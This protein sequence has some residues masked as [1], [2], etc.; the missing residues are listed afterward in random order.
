M[1]KKTKKTK[2]PKIGDTV[3]I[4]NKYNMGSISKEKVGFI[5]VESFVLDGFQSYDIDEA[6]QFYDDYGNTWFTNLAKAKK[7]A[8]NEARKYFGVG[9]WKIV[10]NGHGCW[11]VEEY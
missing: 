8:L 9:R 4:F 5:G 7:A 11:C 1:E 6:E 2:K 10:D 3:Y